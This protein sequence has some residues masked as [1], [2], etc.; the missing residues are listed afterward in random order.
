MLSLCLTNY[1]R[2][3]MLLESFQHV[4]DDPRIREIVISD[5][6]SDISIYEK[7]VEYCKDK[8]KIF[9]HRN[10][11]NLGMSRNKRVAIQ[12]ASNDWCILFDSDNILKPDYLDA[13]FH[14]FPMTETGVS[15]S[16]YQIFCPSAAL[17]EFNYKGFENQIISSQSVKAASKVK[18]FDCLMNT[19]NYVVNRKR[20]LQVHEFDSKVKGS[21]TIHFN[22]LWLKSKG[23]F[24]VVPNMQYFHRV[25]SGSGFMADADYNLRQAEQTKKLIMQL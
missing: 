8:P 23:W 16:S 1:N 20:Y 11:E 10:T 19:C 22:Y 15:T 12:I 9:L 25:H 7:L 14:Y 4:Y 17:P 18:R 2:Y 6:C 24:Y 13:L 21:D 5:D 3:D